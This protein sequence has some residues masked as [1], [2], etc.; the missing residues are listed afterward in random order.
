MPSA[1]L[2]ML[3]EL[4]HETCFAYADTKTQ[5]SCSV[6]LPLLFGNIVQSLYILNLFLEILELWLYSPV[7]VGP[8]WN[9]QD[10]SNEKLV[11]YSF[12]VIRYSFF[13]S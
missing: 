12:F 4:H 10:S 8:D 7:C 6:T 13:R 5:I 2:I 11:R 3:Y 9:P 1:A